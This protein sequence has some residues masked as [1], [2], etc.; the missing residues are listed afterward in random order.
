TGSFPQ[1]DGPDYVP[2]G[3]DRLGFDYWRGYNFH[4]TYFDGWVNVDDWRNER[5]EGYETDGLNRY[6]FEFMDAAGDEP[7]CLF[8]SPHQPHATGGEFA[9]Q[10]CYDRLPRRLELPAN[11]PDP[12]GEEG[13]RAPREMYRHYLAMTLALDDMVGEMLDA[14]DERGLADDTLV[15]FT[16]DHGTQAGAHGIEP[17]AKKMPYEESL[18]VPFVMRLP[19]LLDGGVRRDVLT[20]PVDIFPSLCGL[21]GV[22]TPRTV[23]GVDLSAAWCGRDGARQQDAVLCMNFGGAYDY[24]VDGTEWRAVRTPDHIFTR[25]LDGRE[26]L[27]DLHAD[28]LQ[29]SNLADDEA[30]RPLRNRLDA[31]LAELM[32]EIDDDLVPCT[33][34]R[35]WFDAQRRVVRNASGPL[36]DPEAGPDWSLLG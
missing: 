19:G 25:W 15:I 17:W 34:Y 29:M 18:L 33:A 3:R 30:S 5:W 36:G 7:F 9:P 32:A 4:C 10:H 23:A 35:N 20:S 1:I 21:C 12:D 6:G 27:F 8:L 31:R 13:R 11:V 26:E 2:E 22:P 24:F 14:L 28:P 16:S